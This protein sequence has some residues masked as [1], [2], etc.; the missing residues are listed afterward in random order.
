MGSSWKA[1]AD[2]LIAIKTRLATSE[3]SAKT[4]RKF[5]DNLTVALVAGS[6]SAVVS[7]IP[8]LLLR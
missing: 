1:I 8:Y 3:S 5:R 6:V 4:N 2:D 7:M